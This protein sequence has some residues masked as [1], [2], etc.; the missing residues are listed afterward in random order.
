MRLT[1]EGRATLNRLRCLLQ[2]GGAQRKTQVLTPRALA[3]SGALCADDARP[4]LCDHNGVPKEEADVDEDEQDEEAHGE[5]IRIT[6]R[7][8][9]KIMMRMMRMRMR[10]RTTAMTRIKRTRWRRRMRRMRVNKV[11]SDHVR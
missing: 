6:I 2:D 4:W 1:Y 8:R 11:K 7:M 3:R 5:A 10:K 9:V